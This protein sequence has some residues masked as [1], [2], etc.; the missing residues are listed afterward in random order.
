MRAE[1]VPVEGVG[2][3]GVAV[4]A[5]EVAALVPGGLERPDRISSSMHVVRPF[6]GFKQQRDIS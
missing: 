5:V 1:P 6:L 2:R 4:A 3:A